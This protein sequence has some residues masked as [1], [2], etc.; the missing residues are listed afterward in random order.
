[1]ILGVENQLLHSVTWCVD[2]V[3]NNQVSLDLCQWNQSE[4]TE[5]LKSGCELKKNIE[6]IVS[7]NWQI[8][9]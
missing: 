1:M 8:W 2:V 9:T 6:D 5:K 7:K 3:Y 4:D